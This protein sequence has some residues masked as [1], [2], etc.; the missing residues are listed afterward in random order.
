VSVTFITKAACIMRRSRHRAYVYR[1]VVGLLITII[2]LLFGRGF[3]M[4]YDVSNPPRVPSL[5]LLFLSF[6]KLGLTAFGGPA[7]VAFIRK[8]A[9]D[10]KRWLDDDTF[11]RG[12]AL[13]QTVPGATAMQTCAYVGLELRGVGG[14]AAAFIGFG[15]PA[16]LLMLGLSALYER[17]HSLPAV[18][19]VF[20][21]LRVVIVAV[22]ANASIMFARSNLKRWRD[23]I[24]LASAAIAFWFGL[25]P[26][27][28]VAF[29][30]LLG[31]ILSFRDKVVPGTSSA[32]KVRSKLLPIGGI[33]GSAILAFIPHGRYCRPL[34]RTPERNSVFSQGGRQHS[35]LFCWT[36]GLH[37]ASNGHR[38]SVDHP[39]RDPFR[40]SFGCSFAAGRS[41]LGDSRGRA[42]IVSASLIIGEA[43]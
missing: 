10:D 20:G 38:G 13:C 6:F 28:V 12:V 7:M 30:A 40:R 29:A 9:V 35:L 43:W 5:L 42:S 18:V 19:S 24:I 17:F 14:A 23:A 37:G 15:L 22:V 34:L 25:S 16:F 1:G 33:V 8:M 31:I 11:K 4:G 3:H 2:L 41:H 26:I 21:G 36:A 27:L 39:I 32:R